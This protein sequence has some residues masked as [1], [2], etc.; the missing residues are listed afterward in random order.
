[1][2]L[3]VKNVQ[4]PDGTRGRRYCLRGLP[5]LVSTLVWTAGLCALLL[6]PIPNPNFP[7]ALNIAKGVLLDG[8]AIVVLL[9]T[10][11]YTKWLGLSVWQDGTV[12]F[13][14][15]LRSMSVPVHEVGGFRLMT[16]WPWRT[17]MEK[18]D[19]EVES[20]HGLPAAPTWL[21]RRRAKANDLLRLVW[22]DIRE[23][24]GQRADVWSADSG[25]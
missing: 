7:L 9:L 22:D 17:L 1:M 13:R 4:R 11:R 5:T 18:V 8:A 19:G 15:Y 20:V 14:Y 12:S 25:P 6:G 2:R 23:S 16:G 21:A 3:T 24:N 10:R